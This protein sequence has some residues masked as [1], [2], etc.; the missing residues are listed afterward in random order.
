MKSFA[1]STARLEIGLHCESK[2]KK[3]NARILHGFWHRMFEVYDE[4]GEGV[5]A[6]P[7]DRGWAKIYETHS[8]DTLT[9]E[10]QAKTAGR[11]AEIITC[12]HPILLELDQ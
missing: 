4:L 6:E 7:W 9:D 1:S 11:L 2:D 10:F 12:L 5:S 8:M 3:R